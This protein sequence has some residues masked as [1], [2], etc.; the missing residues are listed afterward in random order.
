M[1]EVSCTH[2]I[3]KLSQLCVSM[4]LPLLV[5]DCVGIDHLVSQCAQ[6]H[7]GPLWDI[8]QLAPVWL[9]HPATKQGPKLQ[10]RIPFKVHSMELHPVKPVEQKYTKC[11]CIMVMTIS[12]P[13]MPPS[14][15]LSKYSEERA[16]STAIRTTDQHVHSRLNLKVE[17]S[18]QH[19][20][21]GRHQRNILKPAHGGQPLDM[22]HP[23]PSHCTHTPDEV[24]FFKDLSTTRDQGH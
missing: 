13:T 24:V 11:K 2:F 20:S 21:V 1:R 14:P 3:E 18:Y 4:S 15:D 22:P 10:N 23:P 16:L 19:I 6:G 9:H 12:P 8:K 17:V 5:F 7:V